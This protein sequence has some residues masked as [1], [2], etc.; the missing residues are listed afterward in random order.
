VFCV[1]GGGGV[2]N[3]EKAIVKIENYFRTLTECVPQVES[4]FHG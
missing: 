4:S 1:W 2:D 3:G